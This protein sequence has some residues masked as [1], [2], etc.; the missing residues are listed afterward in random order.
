MRPSLVPHIEVERF[1][2]KETL[3]TASELFEGLNIY[4]MVDFEYSSS[5]KFE[6]F[7]CNR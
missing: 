2:K 6:F 7:F 5:I 4:S 3:F 1:G